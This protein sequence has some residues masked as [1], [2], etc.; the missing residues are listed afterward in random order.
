[1][2]C[3]MDNI[4]RIIKKNDTI[5]FPFMSLKKKKKKTVQSDY[6]ILWFFQ[7]VWCWVNLFT[8]WSDVLRQDCFSSAVPSSN[9][10]ECCPLQRPAALCVPSR[11][12]VYGFLTPIHTAALNFLLLLQLYK[13]GTC[14]SL[15][16]DS[17]LYFLFLSHCPSLTQANGLTLELV[18]LFFSPSW[19][20]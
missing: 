19:N 3:R 1:M 6:P 4:F 7:E 17:L 20:I 5:S 9:L 12:K 2:F 13:P 10:P 11:L 16:N 14:L 18:F 15:L 8:P